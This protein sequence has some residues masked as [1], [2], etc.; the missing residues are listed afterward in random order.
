VYERTACK[1]DSPLQEHAH[2]F[3][4]DFVTAI[5]HIMHSWGLEEAQLV[6]IMADMGFDISPFMEA[7][8]QELDAEERQV[9]LA[10][11]NETAPSA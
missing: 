6:T 7:P 5:R 1:N 4:S 8:D 10:E 9:A 11:Q 2:A 3:I